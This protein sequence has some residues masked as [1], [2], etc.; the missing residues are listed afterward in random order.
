M[1]THYTLGKNDKTAIK[2]HPLLIQEI[3]PQINPELVHS[4]TFIR[5]ESETS[6]R[7]AGDT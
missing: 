6:K 2:Y 7:R 1:L 4:I 3:L 5:K